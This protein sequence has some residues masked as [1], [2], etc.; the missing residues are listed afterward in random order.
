MPEA[1]VIISFYNNVKF[2][3]MLL[4]GLEQQSCQDFEVIIADDGSNEQALKELKTLINNSKL[5]IKHIWHE[6][7]GFRKT[8]I[9]NQAIRTSNSDYL[10]F[11]DMDCIPHPEFVFEHLKN[12]QK[13]HFLTGRRV[14]LSKRFC[15]HLDSEKIKKGY[16]QKHF[17]QLVF[18]SFLGQSKHIEKGI[19]IRSPWLRKQINNK[20]R[21][22]LGCNFSIFKDDLIAVNGFDERYHVAGVGEDTDIDYRLR[23]AGFK[24]KTLQNIAIQYH[25]YHKLLPRSDNNHALFKQVKKGRSAFTPY[26]L[27]QKN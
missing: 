21:G 3:S 7:I 20:E 19:Y 22:L 2:L 18:D 9:L 1:S 13:G 8:T 6:D 5:S 16:I 4:A 25:L 12:A 24:I 26:G 23:L 27:K 15:Q 17:F 10:I 14:M 11:I